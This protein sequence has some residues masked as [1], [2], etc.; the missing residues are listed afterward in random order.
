MGTCRVTRIDC[1]KNRGVGQGNIRF[2]TSRSRPFCVR[3]PA[4]SF[5]PI[6]I[7]RH[8]CSYTHRHSATCY[9]YI[10]AHVYAHI[11]M[12]VCVYMHINE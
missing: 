11:G 9:L 1:M 6:V 2:P 3:L 7:C 12:C 10:Y 4:A 5:S 8:I